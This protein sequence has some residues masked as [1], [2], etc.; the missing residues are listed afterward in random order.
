MN[1]VTQNDPQA[2]PLEQSE[3]VYHVAIVG[4]GLAGLT[5]AIQLA[6]DGFSVVVLEK[7]MYPFHR[8]CG[9][10]I[11][12]ESWNFLESL[13]YP[14]SDMDLPVIKTLQ[15][16]APGGKI[17]EH[18]LPLGGFGI[19]RYKLDAELAALARYQ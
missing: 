8:V 4:G 2:A 10:Y 9:E 1:P 11:S 6:K 16:S 7:E 13:G 14:L 12:F 15:V 17:I 5:M 3:R 19:S 18:D